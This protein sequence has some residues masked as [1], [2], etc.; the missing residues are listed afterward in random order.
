MLIEIRVV[1]IL[2]KFEDQKLADKAF[3]WCFALK[4]FFC[5]SNGVFLKYFRNV[6]V[7]E[8]QKKCERNIKKKAKEMWK[9]CKRN[10]KKLCYY[11]S[12]SFTFLLRFFY[13][14]FCISF[15]FLMHFFDISFVFLLHLHF[16]NISKRPHLKCKRN[17]Y[18]S[19]QCFLNILKTLHA[20]REEVGP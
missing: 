16:R 8:M 2:L 1:E 20:H 11:M 18:V 17:A 9:K 15:T 6:N 5:I 13:I 4:H 10:L 12:C 7:N 14:S 3:A 19:K